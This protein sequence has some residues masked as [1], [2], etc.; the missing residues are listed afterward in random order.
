MVSMKLNNE[1]WKGVRVGTD[2]GVACVEI[3]GTDRGMGAWLLENVVEGVSGA[4][5]LGA[6][7]REEAEVKG[8]SIDGG[9]V[10]SLGMT[11][12]CD[13]EVT[14]LWIT[15]SYGHRTVIQV[16][17]VFALPV[18]SHFVI[19]FHQLIVLGDYSE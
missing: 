9:T 10:E 4:V 13:A 1:F 14:S 11:G 18:K 16:L 2:A 6:L 15:P 17:G 7:G 8:N 3:A 5:E 19:D 12:V